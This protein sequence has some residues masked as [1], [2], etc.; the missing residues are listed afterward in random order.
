MK[1]LNLKEL[2][3]TFFSLACLDENFGSHFGAEVLG[4]D[5]S[6]GTWLQVDVPNG[7]LGT[8]DYTMKSEVMYAS[9]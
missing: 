6:N 8:M 3:K 4:F 5:K 1:T 9:R 2:S 7:D